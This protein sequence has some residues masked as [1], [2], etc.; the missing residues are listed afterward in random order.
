MAR[1]K[2]DL[3]QVALL[4]VVGEV[5]HHHVFDH[6]LAQGR[7][8]AGGRNGIAKWGCVAHGKQR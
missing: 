6:P 2:A 7:N 4:R 5:A 3:A 1:K 8:P